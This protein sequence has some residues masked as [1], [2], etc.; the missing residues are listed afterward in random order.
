LVYKS[1]SIPASVKYIG[2]FAFAN[3]RYLEELTLPDGLT[4]LSYA[5]F[6]YCPSLRSVRIPSSLT[7]VSECAFEECGLREVDIQPGVVN[8]EKDAFR[9][10]SLRTL[11]IPDTVKLIGESS[12]ADCSSLT[13]VTILSSGNTVIGKG[14]F[15]S[16]S[17]INYLHIP[18]GVT[19]IEFEAFYS[20]SSLTY[21]NLPSTVTSISYDAFGNCKKILGIAYHGLRN[22]CVDSAFRGCLEIS[23]VCA[24]TEYNSTEFC[25]I[26]EVCT[27]VISQCQAVYD[28]MNHCYELGCV[29]GTALLKRRRNATLWESKASKCNIYECLND[30]GPYYLHFC[31]TAPSLSLKGLPLLISFAMILIL[32]L[33][34]I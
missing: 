20:C 6:Y 14:A 22:P 34:S 5:A 25:G 9:S 12:F 29:N 2:I 17:R 4:T 10:T 11:L 19:K 1:L 31:S 13:N 16:C 8:I 15:R 30:S 32:F 18:E 28:K 3:L 33:H 7:N 24:P 23:A 26:T 21:L 27:S